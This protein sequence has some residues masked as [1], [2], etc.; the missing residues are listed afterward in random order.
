MLAPLLLSRLLL[1]GDMA[2]LGCDMAPTREP[3][4]RLEGASTTI[5]CKEV[6]HDSV[7]L[8][9]ALIPGKNNKSGQSG[10]TLVGLFAGGLAQNFRPVV[11]EQ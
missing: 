2:C 4:A 8:Q 5:G 7:W 11:I 6:S 10:D 1:Y 3:W 9:H